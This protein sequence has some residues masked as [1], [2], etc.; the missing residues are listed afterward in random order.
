M[1]S[2]GAC[3]RRILQTIVG[4]PI[5]TVAPSSTAARRR[6][7]SKKPFTSIAASRLD[8]ETG[9][10]LRDDLEPWEG[11]SDQYRNL[12]NVQK[13]T[14]GPEADE[15]GEGS[16]K[17]VAR[18]KRDI[19]TAP[20]WVVQKQLQYLKDPLKLADYVVRRCQNGGFEE[21]QEVVRAASKY[22]ACTVSWNHLIDYQMSQS[23]INSAFKTYHEV[24]LPLLPLK[25]SANPDCF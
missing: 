12:S 3:Q 19:K 22:M 1:L 4:F 25:S 13:N 10:S 23:N 8:A 24:A 17:L 20:N 14:E 7:I 21:A 16:G 11:V 5:T 15:D 6:Q 9:S 2:C 18:T